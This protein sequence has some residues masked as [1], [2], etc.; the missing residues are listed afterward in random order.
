MCHSAQKSFRAK[1]PL[2]LLLLLLQQHNKQRPKLQRPLTSET[3][4]KAKAKAEG[5]ANVRPDPTPT[6]KRNPGHPPQQSQRAARDDLTSVNTPVVVHCFHLRTQAVVAFTPVVRRLCLRITNSTLCCRMCWT[7]TTATADVHAV[8]CLARPPD[9]LSQSQD[10]INHRMKQGL[11][12]GRVCRSVERQPLQAPA[13]APTPTPT[14]KPR[15]I[16]AID[17]D[18]RSRGDVGVGV[19]PDKSQPK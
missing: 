4:A 6:P 18:H 16:N 19:A 3:A 1:L 2:L 12:A 15:R 10:K 5:T 8:Q 17:L 11:R 14:P 13:Q 9:H 7:L